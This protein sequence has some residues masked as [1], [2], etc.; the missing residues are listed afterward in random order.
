MKT[1]ATTRP[2]GG[3]PV[4]KN[5]FRERA[6]PLNAEVITYRSVGVLNKLYCR[7]DNVQCTFRLTSTSCFEFKL[8]YFKLKD[9][10]NLLKLVT[11]DLKYCS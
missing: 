6:L 1:G 10:S 8:S 4:S 3:K 11:I 2:V 9:L 5:P 7:L